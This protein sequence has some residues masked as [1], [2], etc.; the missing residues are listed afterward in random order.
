M[1]EVIKTMIRMAAEDGVITEKEKALIIKKAKDLGEDVDMVELAIEGELG[2]LKKDAVTKVSKGEKC[3]NCGEIIPAGAAV[4]LSCGFE[5]RVR[6]ANSSTLQ[7][8][9]ELQIIND[10][11]QAKI[12]ALPTRRGVT[13]IRRDAVAQKGALISSFVIPNTKEDL[14]AL[15]AF[16]SPKA[17]PLK[18][19]DTL[20][21]GV[22][23]N[24][25]SY[26]ILFCNC[27]MMAKTSFPNDP[28]FQ[29]YYKEHAAK[30]KKKRV[31]ERNHK[32]ATIVFAAVFVIPIIVAM[33]AAIFG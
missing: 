29:H 3:P 14:L 15:L 20:S 17:D 19:E 9:E 5:L 31:S 11:A 22:E 10:K 2:Q 32:I 33:I 24:S 6:K 21:E 23:D 18:D 26:W 12:D 27:I 25:H 28:A 16:S 1:N 4:C 8:Q 7:L 30:E 13:G